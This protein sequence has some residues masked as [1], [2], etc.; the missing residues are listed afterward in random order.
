MTDELTWEDL[1]DAVLVARIGRAAGSAQREA[2][3]EEIYRRHS[4]AVL[5]VCGGMLYRD[6]DSA[7]ATAQ[8]ALVAAYRDLVE[9]R[10]P[11]DP[12]K[13]RAWLCGIARYRCHEE[14]RRRN[15]ESSLSEDVAD[16]DY[17]S[18]SRQ[19]R[20]EVDRILDVVAA[21][22]TEPQ[23]QIYQLVIRQ[24]LRGQALAAARGVSEK[25]ANDNTYENKDRLWAGFGSYVLA[26]EGRPHCPELAAILDRGAWDGETF[27]RIL[28][29]RI[30]RHLGTCKTCG[31]CG[32]CR[33]T[34]D[35]LI[36]P[37]APAL[38]PILAGAMLHRHVMSAVREIS[39]SQPVRP[40]QSS[41]PPDPPDGPPRSASRAG[42]G[43]RLPLPALATATAVI[44]FVL[45]LF[46][47][48]TVVGNT[49]KPPRQPL[50]PI[51]TVA[52][53]MPTIAYTT[54]NS[55]AIRHGSAPPQTLATLPTGTSA[56][57]LRWS[58]DGRYLAWFSQPPHTTT[59]EVHVTST[60]TRVTH[61]WP[62]PNCVS[63]AFQGDHLLVG[64]LQATS[65]RDYPATGGA[66]TRITV[67]AG[68]TAPI[69]SAE[70]LASTPHDTSVV[71]FSGSYIGN[72]DR[73]YTTTTSG[74]AELLA[75]IPH[76]AA[77]GGDR[78]VGATGLLGL[79]ADGTILAYAGNILGG[80]T[81]EASD[82]VTVVNLRQLTSETVPLPADRAQP[83]RASSVWVDSSD[84]VYASAWHQP[85]NA[86][87]SGAVPNDVIQP[88]VYRLA[89][90]Q[91]IATTATAFIGA[92]GQDQWAAMLSSSRP[93]RVNS[94][95]LA[96]SLI[97]SLHRSRIVLG[98][99]VTSF[100]WAPAAYSD[101]TTPP[102]SSRALFAAAVAAQHFSPDPARYPTGP[103]GQPGAYHRVCITGWA[104]ATISHPKVGP[105]DGD[106]LFRSA[107][108]KWV[109][110]SE[111]GGVPAD[112][113]LEHAGVPASAAKKLWPP[114]HSAPA[115]YCP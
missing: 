57:Q 114:S 79:G 66:M 87:V 32:T 65:M 25:E 61:T 70:P 92:A 84:Q 29:L 68:K 30:V 5:A 38:V 35:E 56:W 17:E 115:S 49:R 48:R 95:G 33:A 46:I 16:D 108:G 23:Q 103:E 22:F 94:P 97:A 26:L 9:G 55:L 107:G 98:R 58:W 43:S 51:T 74:K 101:S 62:C 13:L 31:N 27:T 45:A 14:I 69:L 76:Y 100:A 8:I 91:W 37:F 47:T 64:D 41:R 34:K 71:F 28:R 6:P 63:A 40:P 15:R 106:T 39:A 12:Q 3:F 99:G 53:T 102:C 52:A 104:I 81:G 10:P 88:R 50:P 11:R 89:A 73:L 78:D 72:N 86:T 54:G 67:S 105:T 80:D 36:R 111:V 85:G 2:A 24:G 44:F 82:S 42:L 96:G 4:E 109:Y 77:P 112:C 93:L 7:Q 1:P 90:R 19:R 113:V 21:T 59:T 20:A 83:L 18:A 75:R 110:Q 60:A